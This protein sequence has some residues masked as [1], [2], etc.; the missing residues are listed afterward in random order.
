MSAN[1]IL[2]SGASGIFFLM[3]IYGLGDGGVTK[4]SI[5]F[6]LIEMVV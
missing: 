4:K 6:F 2:M 1:T 3:A 5:Y